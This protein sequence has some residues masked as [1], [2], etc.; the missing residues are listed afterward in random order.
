MGGAVAA[1]LRR[2][3]WGVTE[4]QHLVGVDGADLLYGFRRDG[5]MSVAVTGHF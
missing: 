3:F 2:E 5:Y 1:G 4:S